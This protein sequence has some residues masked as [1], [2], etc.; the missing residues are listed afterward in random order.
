MSTL[1]GSASQ[2]PTLRVPVEDG[3]GRFVDD[4]GPAPFEPPDQLRLI[5]APSQPRQPT[6][7]RGVWWPRSRDIAGELAALL[8]A[9]DTYLGAPLTRMSLNPAAWGK[10]PRRLYAGRRVIRLAWFSSIDPATVGFGATPLERLTLCVIPPECQPAT[11]QGIL[12]A[13][14]DGEGWPLEP[15]AIFQFDRGAGTAEPR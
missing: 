2:F 3:E 8:P 13:L 6:R 7:I 9:A 11:G 14:R 12:R 4:G 5:W 1:L 10:H 15:S